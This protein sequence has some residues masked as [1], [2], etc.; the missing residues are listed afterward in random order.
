MIGTLILAALIVILLFGAKRLPEIMGALGKSGQTMKRPKQTFTPGM[1]GR[2]V[3][4]NRRL[5]AAIRKEECL[6]KDQGF[7][8][9]EIHDIIIGALEE[10]FN[11][12]DRWN[13]LEEPRP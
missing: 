13:F 2:L 4:C 5:E 1:K 9:K 8:R 6:L 10:V 11:Q 3:E 7:T 12:R